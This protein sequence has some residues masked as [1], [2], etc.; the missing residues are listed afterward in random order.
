MRN[1]EG[2]TRWPGIISKKV[3]RYCTFFSLFSTMSLLF[4]LSFSFPLSFDPLQVS[5]LLSLFTLIQVN[6]YKLKNRKEKGKNQS[7]A[8]YFTFVLLLL[9]LLL[10]LLFDLFN[11]LYLVL[12]LCYAAGDLTQYESYYA[13]LETEISIT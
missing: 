1:S 5:V 9:L 10:L 6:R 3:K 7:K 4:L 8:S 12:S 11:L 2:K 13:Q